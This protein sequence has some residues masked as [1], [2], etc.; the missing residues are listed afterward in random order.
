[1]SI[2]LVAQEPK[3]FKMGAGEGV[4]KRNW[5]FFGLGLGFGALMPDSLAQAPA[6][7]LT[8]GPYLTGLSSRSVHLLWST[9]QPES[10]AVRFW[11]ADP[12]QAVTLKEPVPRLNHSIAL[13]GLLPNTRYPYEVLAGDG[14]PLTGEGFWFRTAPAPGDAAV[15]F[16][17]GALGDSG[18]GSEAQLRVAKRLEEMAPDFFIHTGDVFY[19]K[20]LDR[21][22]FKPYAEVLKRAGVCPARGNH[23]L[24]LFRQL[25]E[26]WNEVFPLPLEDPAG[27]AE[28]CSDFL[29][30][31]GRIEDPAGRNYFSLDW[32]NAHVAVLDTVGDFSL[33]SIQLEWLCRDLARAR[34]RQADWLIVI[35][36]DPPYTMGLHFIDKEFTTEVLPVLAER[37]GID[38]VLSGDDHNYQ[39]TQPLSAGKIRD[40]WQD[41]EFVE[42]RGTFFIVSGGGGATLYPP[43]WGAPFRPLFNRFVPE[44]HALEISID[45]KKLALRAVAAGGEVLDQ[46]TVVKGR[47]PPP[48][49]FIRG[50]ADLN[51]TL[52]IADAIAILSYLFLGW[53]LSCPAMANVDGSEG[54][55]PESRL[56]MADAIGIL[57][58]LFLGGPPP[59]P[60]YPGCGEPTEEDENC[61]KTQ[62]Y[63]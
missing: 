13:A 15:P 2:Y 11:S 59:R 17:I 6:A 38:L 5:W 31:P 20:D 30:E 54:G 7:T 48:F 29:A 22:F 32:G 16:R 19:V 26:P 36:H 14:S 53:P 63:P 23:D 12:A 61:L 50:D 49:R 34:R 33:G 1:M 24:G 25:E 44:F 9:D 8:R 58:H 55:D 27:P 62:C 41:P 3:G 45:G 60:P 37:F 43:W 51:R 56:D 57:L 21:V 35:A 40:A 47:P 18:N 28:A 10:G 39:R 52:E 4:M 46:F 42:P